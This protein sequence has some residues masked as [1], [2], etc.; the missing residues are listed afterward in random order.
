MAGE[1]EL[2]SSS[3]VIK[4]RESTDHDSDAL[5]DLHPV[6]RQ[7]YL[8]RGVTHEQQLDRTLKNLPNYQRLSGID[9]AVSLIKTAI[10]TDQKI[11]I[12]A[13]F[14]A[15]GA[16]S[17]AVAIRGLRMLG[18]TNLD[19]VVPDRFKFGYG[20]TPEI[21]DVALELKPDLLITVD[22]GISSAVSYTHLTLPTSDLV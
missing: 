15:D 1:T 4:H 10:K 11:L 6:L 17:C 20:L 13:D 2:A 18:A 19:F 16:T 3:I 7:V 12:V 9:K 21:V 8:N 5:P 22:N 14:D